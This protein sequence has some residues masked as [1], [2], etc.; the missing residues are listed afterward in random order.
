[1]LAGSCLDV[2]RTIDAQ[3]LESKLLNQRHGPVW[4]PKPVGTASQY[5]SR[6]SP[7][8][9]AIL[10]DDKSAVGSPWL[11]WPLAACPCSDG[12]S[13]AIYVQSRPA[14]LSLMVPNYGTYL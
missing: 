6:A 8:S 3:T 10:T 7:L 4:T 14:A 13:P 2:T 9:A 1:M 11:R 12:G 5:A